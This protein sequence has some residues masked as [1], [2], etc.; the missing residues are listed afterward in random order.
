MPLS[1]GELL[2]VCMMRA[3]ADTFRNTHFAPANPARA[4]QAAG[5]AARDGADRLQQRRADHYLP[6]RPRAAAERVET[7]IHFNTLLHAV[8]EHRQLRIVYYSISRNAVSTRVIDAY[9]IFFR[10]G[11]WYVY[12]YC[13]LRREM[14]DFAL[15]RLRDAEL[16]PTTFPPPDLNEVRERLAQRF[17]L[18]EETTLRGR[19]LVRHRICPPHPRARLARHAAH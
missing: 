15:E 10:H 14:R 12:A 19:H 5:D 13:H 1:E 18:I 17:S 9:H 4:E 8:D 3:M 11:M 6:E 16:L 2:A 7:S